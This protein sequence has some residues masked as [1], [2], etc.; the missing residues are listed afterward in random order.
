M[1]PNSQ[2]VPIYAKLSRQA[3]LLP[4]AVHLPSNPQL[5]DRKG[6]PNSLFEN[7]CCVFY[8]VQRILV[9]VISICYL[10]CHHVRV[11]SRSSIFSRERFAS[12][13]RD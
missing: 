10:L 5:L 1:L 3:P 8:F 6:F 7:I 13:L 2:L 11:S 12:F 4:S 9:N